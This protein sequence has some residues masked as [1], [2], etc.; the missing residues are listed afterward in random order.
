MPFWHRQ[1]DLNI[2]SRIRSVGLFHKQPKG[3][4]FPKFATFSDGW[5]QQWVIPHL[6]NMLISCAA[7]GRTT[8]LSNVVDS[9][10]NLS[11]QFHFRGIIERRGKCSHSFSC[12]PRHHS[13]S[14]PFRNQCLR[15]NLPITML[16]GQN[17][18]QTQTFL[19]G[20]F[21]FISIAFRTLLL[22]TKSLCKTP[23]LFQNI[24]V[25]FSFPILTNR[26][27][28]RGFF[29]QQCSRS[30]NTE[31]VFLFELWWRICLM[32]KWTKMFI[33]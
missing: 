28:D 30:N 9:S 6:V 13:S 29:H 14:M 20:L 2:I 1:V 17:S 21:R 18:I 3:L 4:L 32:R 8:N 11:F 16:H 15:I 19:Y 5:T 27:Y 12:C 31:V 33:K 22:S 26:G 25:H 24:V 23:P 7:H 10:G